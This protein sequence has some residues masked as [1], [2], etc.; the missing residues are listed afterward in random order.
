MA[1]NTEINRPTE[2]DALVF[3]HVFT[4]I[5]TRLPGRRLADIVRRHAPL[6]ALAQRVDA[7][8]FKRP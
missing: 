5:T 4:V 6:L 2:L 3:G 8:C 7:T 1:V